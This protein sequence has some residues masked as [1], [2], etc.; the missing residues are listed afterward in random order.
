MACQ[1]QAWA[2]GSIPFLLKWGLGLSPDALAKRL[3]IVRPSLPRW[4]G[5]VE[6]TGLALRRHG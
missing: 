1:P 6:V 5:R 2:A 4:L 3:V